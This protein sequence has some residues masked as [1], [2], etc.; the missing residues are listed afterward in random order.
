MQYMVDKQHVLGL[1]QSLCDDTRKTFKRQLLSLN[2]AGEVAQ[3]AQE[4]YRGVAL[5]DL[6]HAMVVNPDVDDDDRRVLRRVVKLMHQTVPRFTY[7]EP[8]V[9]I[10]GDE[11]R[12]TR[13][14]EDNTMI[15]V[16]PEQL[17]ATLNDEFYNETYGIDH[18]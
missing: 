9:E 3:T 6:W 14:D 8:L 18:V 1:M 11:H 12:T 10:I 5:Y 15:M 13:L 17:L 2:S 4:E 16:Q 7:K